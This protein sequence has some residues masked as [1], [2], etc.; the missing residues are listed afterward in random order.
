MFS[1]SCSCWA[2]FLEQIDLKYCVAAQSVFNSSVLAIDPGLVAAHV[3]AGLLL[4]ISVYRWIIFE[5]SLGN[6]NCFEFLRICY[7]LNISTLI[8]R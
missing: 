4:Y 8:G 3:D 6:Y 1:L 7:I 2:I 5:G